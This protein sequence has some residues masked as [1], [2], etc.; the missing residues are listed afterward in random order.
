MQPF[1]NIFSITMIY[2]FYS[3]LKKTIVFTLALLSFCLVFSACSKKEVDY[4]SYVSERRDNIFVCQTDE[5]LIKIY[6]SKK[7]TPYLCDGIK[8]AVTP[9]TEIFLTADSGE[10]EYFVYFFANGKKYGGDMSYDN[11]KQTYF[12]TLTLD[13]SAL[14]DIPLEIEYDGGKV[15]LNAKS[16]KENGLLS[17]EQIVEKVSL[18]EKE[19][20]KNLTKE[21][22]FQG[23]IY[24]RLIYENGLY[25]FVGIIDKN[26]NMLSV[27]CDGKTGKILAK[28]G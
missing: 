25:Y 15:A 23:E 5:F 19:F 1:F 12:Y 9:R 26:G 3:R 17:P 13:I 14:E 2:R 10:K 16:V 22:V 28:R 18:A 7:E 21:N 11:V 6:S 4:F 27:L 8:R 20:F 24:V